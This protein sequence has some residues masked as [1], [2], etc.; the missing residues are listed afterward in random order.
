MFNNGTV[1]LK[2]YFICLYPLD[3]SLVG[4]FMKISFS[5]SQDSPTDEAHKE[6]S[7]EL[8]RHLS[9]LKERWTGREDKLSSISMGE[10]RLLLI[11]VSYGFE[12]MATCALAANR[13]TY[14]NGAL[15]MDLADAANQVTNFM[16]A[17]FILS[18]LEAFLADTNI[19]R[20]KS[21]LISG[22]VEFLAHHPNLKPPLSTGTAGFKAALPSHGADQCDEK[23]P[24]EAR[25]M[26]SFFNGLWLAL[27]IGGAISSTLILWIQDRGLG[28][29]TIAIL[30]AVIIFGAGLPLYRFKLLKG[31]VLSK[32]FCR[33]K[34][35]YVAAI[36]NRKLQLPEDPT[37]LYEIEGKEAAIETEFLPHRDIYRCLDK[38]AIQTTPIGET[39]RPEAPNPWKLCRITDQPTGITHL[40][41]VGVGLVLSSLSMAVAATMEVKCKGVAQD[42]N[43]LDAIPGVQVQPSPISVFWLSF[44]YFIFSVADMFTNVGL[45]EFF[46]SE[47]PN[48]LKSISTYFLWTSMALG[49]F[50]SAILINIMNS[51]TKNS[52]KSGG[53]C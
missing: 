23:D 19:G 7:Q 5:Q 36:L 28:L 46:Y 44:Q 31:L 1:S 42:H 53:W 25:D 29:C 27:C 37:E 51:A 20:Y 40:Q 49:Y 22:S 52:T 24:K 11:L 43:M 38:A 32:R 2:W 21:L 6:P 41:R 30:L 18:I 10:E 12:H 50:L 13:V 26:S 3:Q 45:L 34:S 15:H 4:S 47:E 8:W 35:V 33:F 16:G 48:A 17:S 9:T 39:G 14:F